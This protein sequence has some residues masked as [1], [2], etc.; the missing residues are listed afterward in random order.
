M[1]DFFYLHFGETI[2]VTFTGTLSNNGINMQAKLEF[3]N[4]DLGTDVTFGF[5]TVMK[6]MSPNGAASL[7]FDGLIGFTNTQEYFPGL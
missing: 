5:F 4:L 3:L 6:L 1:C 7:T 2:D